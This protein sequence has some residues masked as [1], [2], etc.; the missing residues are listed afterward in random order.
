[1][2]YNGKQFRALIPVHDILSG[3][4][5]VIQDDK[6]G[7]LAIFHH[8]GTFYVTSNICPHHHASVLSQGYVE[9]GVVICPL[10]NNEYSLETGA[11]LNGGADIKVYDY[12]V[13]N[14]ILY[15]EDIPAKQPKWMSNF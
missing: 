13:E 15:I 3:Q 14:S 11:C 1:M 2:E 8:N 10:H 12:Y 5:A 7:D 4:A 9:N 6:E